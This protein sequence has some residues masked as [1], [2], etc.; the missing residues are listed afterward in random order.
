MEQGDEY[1]DRK[2]LLSLNEVQNEELCLTACF[3]SEDFF[4]MKNLGD[5]L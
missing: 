5:L 4:S 1:Q 3:W 2:N